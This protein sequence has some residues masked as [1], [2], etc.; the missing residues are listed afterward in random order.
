MSDAVK[1]ISDAE[2]QTLVL[3]SKL[4]V[5]VDMWAPWCGPCRMLS[6]LLDELSKSYAGKVTFFK[7]NTDENPAVPNQFNIMSIPTL[8][9]FKNGKLLDRSVGVKPKEVLKKFID[10]ATA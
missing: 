2:F 1:A 4:P 3:N 6:P 10:Q 5:L 7:M 9:L 8:L